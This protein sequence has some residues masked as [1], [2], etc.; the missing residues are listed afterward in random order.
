MDE[1]TGDSYEDKAEKYADTVDSK[2]WNAY[3]ER[4]AVLSL[5]P[6]LEDARVL[7]AGC[8]SGWYAETMLRRGANVTAFDFNSEFVAITRARVGQQARVLQ[9]DLARPLD[10]AQDGEFDVVVCP[11]VMHYLKDWLPALREFH[12]VLKPQGVLVFSTHHPFADWKWFDK[13][14]YFA[15]ELL[16]DAWEDVG[17]I[18][19]FHRPLS[20]ISRDLA[21]AGFSIERLLEPQP[22]DAFRRA[23]ADEYERLMKNPHFLVV[24]AVKRTKD[25]G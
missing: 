5:L 10:F 22:T 13:D 14:D 23:N 19:Y 11:L 6:T 12:R 20:A 25:I 15:L 16:E 21:A 18:T 9:A 2:P 24:R 17:K 8:G 3:Y 1:H 4:P 7:D